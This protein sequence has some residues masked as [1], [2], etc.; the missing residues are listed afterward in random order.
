[1]VYPEIVAPRS[2]NRATVLPSAFRVHQLD[3][4]RRA[5]QRGTPRRWPGSSQNPA[6]MSPPHLM[7]FR[8]TLPANK[9]QQQRRALTKVRRYVFGLLEGIEAGH[10]PAS[11]KA[12]AAIDSK[13]LRLVMRPSTSII[14]LIGSSSAEPMRPQSTRLAKLRQS[15]SLSSVQQLNNSSAVNDWM[16][17]HISA[18][19]SALPFLH[20]RA[21]APYSA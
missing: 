8:P 5:P 21:I 6:L 20:P 17:G 15:G 12:Q 1:M 9:P 7:A 3:P 18:P 4:D 19:L 11:T 14:V 2:G 13:E 10:S 16:T